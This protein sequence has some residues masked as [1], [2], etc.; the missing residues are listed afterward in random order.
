MK[1]K[2]LSFIK[3]K[4]HFPKTRTLQVQVETKV[5]MVKIHTGD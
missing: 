5:M 2:R 1:Q 3:L 4:Q